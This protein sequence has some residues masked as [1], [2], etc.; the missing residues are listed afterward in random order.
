MS[1]PRKNL[2]EALNP[3]S[4]D[5]MPESKAEIKFAIEQEKQSVEALEKKFNILKEE[6]GSKLQIWDIDIDGIKEQ[7][8]ELDLDAKD[9]DLENAKRLIEQARELVKQ[10]N[11]EVHL[12]MMQEKHA[13]VEGIELL[14][15]EYVDE[16]YKETIDELAKSVLSGEITEVLLKSDKVKQLQEELGVSDDELPMVLNE[17]VQESVNITAEELKEDYDKEHTGRKIAGSIGRSMLAGMGTSAVVVGGIG[18]TGGWG[19]LGSAMAMGVYKNIDKYLSNKFSL[20]KHKKGIQKNIGDSESD[21]STKLHEN[22]VRKIQI[23]K[24]EQV[25]EQEGIQTPDSISEQ[26][27][28]EYVDGKITK[29]DFAK[30]LF[31]ER[32]KSVETAGMTDDE[33]E[34]VKQMN[35]ALAVLDATNSEL[36]IERAIAEQARISKEARETKQAREQ[37]KKD[38]GRT[39]AG[40]L[41]GARLIK[42]KVWNKQTAKE[43]GKGFGMGVAARLSYRIPVLKEI[44]AFYGGV[45][46]GLALGEHAIGS[47]KWL[48]KSPKLKEAAKYIT[49]FAGGVGM[50]TMSFIGGDVHHMLSETKDAQ[51]NIDWGQAFGKIGHEIKLDAIEN[52]NVLGARPAEVVKFEAQAGI[53]SRD[54]LSNKEMFNVAQAMREQSDEAQEKILA[55]YGEND[56]FSE[57]FFRIQRISDFEAGMNQVPGGGIDTSDRVLNENEAKKAA[58]YWIKQKEAFDSALAKGENQDGGISED[59]YNQK[60]EEMKDMRA[61][62]TN[63][64]SYREFADLVDIHTREIPGAVQKFEIGLH[65]VD[66]HDGY[67]DAELITSVQEYNELEKAIQDL[68]D[69]ANTESSITD[70]E[71]SELHALE[72]Q[73][74][75]LEKYYFGDNDHGP[76]IAVART[77][78]E[79]VKIFEEENNI[80]TEGGYGQSEFDAI[81]EKIRQFENSEDLRDQA[82]AHLLRS[83]YEHNQAYQNAR[84]SFGSE[85]GQ[86]FGPAAKGERAQIVSTQNLE[87][88]G[89]EKAN[90]TNEYSHALGGKPLEREFGKMVIGRY[91]ET[92]E[93]QKPDLTGMEIAK[94]MNISQNLINDL[95]EHGYLQDQHIAEYNHDTDTLIIHDAD[96]FNARVQYWADHADEIE[97]KLETGAL[98]YADNYTNETVNEM[99]NAQRAGDDKVEIPRFSDEDQAHIDAAEKVVFSQNVEHLEDS[100]FHVQATEIADEN[101]GKFGVQFQGKTVEVRMAKGEITGMVV[102][103]Q[104]IIPSE[105]EHITLDAAKDWITTKINEM[106]KQEE[107]EPAVTNQKAEISEKLK[108]VGEKLSQAKTQ[109]QSMEVFEGWINKNTPKE[110][111]AYFI[112]SPHYENFVS[113]LKEQG[114]YGDASYVGDSMQGFWDSTKQVYGDLMNSDK[115]E[116]RIGSLNPGDSL[117]AYNEETG[118]LMELK[119]TD[120]KIEVYA[121]DEQGNAHQEV[122]RKLFFRSQKSFDL[123]DMKH[124]REIL[125]KKK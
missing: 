7:L 49:G 24:Y 81:N 40:T 115:A 124:I 18:A 85:S 117:I 86:G 116:H 73:K 120:E 82:A 77:T 42:E 4:M 2:L 107:A 57:K 16:E 105:K 76:D 63:M 68:K 51:G 54:G 103:G 59:V 80:I 99:A 64:D 48:E 35:Q 106:P 71:R 118:R 74:Q 55:F 98:A 21:S 41:A 84:E 33:K 56:A 36:D 58:Q 94:T 3:E 67:T 102:D 45:S 92:G 93:G 108:D 13:D 60:M 122:L 10:I 47:L 111:V 88:L 110:V 104:S 11:S 90:D 27:R 61:Y 65:N 50:C 39:V 14:N 95:K 75:E 43:F 44:V 20:V 29:D 62:Y 32:G 22:M 34:K 28:Q 6:Y 123:D 78:A 96:K 19:I 119:R 101:D 66:G 100:N 15:K 72:I 46:M 12:A 121:I 112:K 1:R 79:M 52:V 9:A 26:L 83:N 23:R 17:I 31:E 109:E 87:Q 125:N 69:R 70:S 8:T 37:I 30:K 38:L 91:I 89:F 114:G 25:L 97:G 113:E 53:D 5:K